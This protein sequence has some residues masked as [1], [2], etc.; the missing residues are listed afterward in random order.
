MTAPSRRGGRARANRTFTLRFTGGVLLYFAALL[1][2]GLAEGSG[3]A[4][5][6]PALLAVPAAAVMAWANVDMYRSGDEFER[7]KVAEAILIA[8][9]LSA[10]LILAVGVMQFYVLPELNWIFAFSI[11]MLTWI[12]GTVASAIRYR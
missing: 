2:A 12:V 9:V 3:I 11:L 5:W 1:L 6:V 10:P 8:F 7:R 4:P